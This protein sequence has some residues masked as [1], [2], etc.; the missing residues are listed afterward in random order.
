M[1]GIRENLPSG[2]EIGFFIGAE[3]ES[4]S[5]PAEISTHRLVIGDSIIFRYLPAAVDSNSSSRIGAQ[6]VT[7]IR[8]LGRGIILKREIDKKIT[9]LTTAAAIWFAAPIGMAI[10]FEFYATLLF[11]PS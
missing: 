4:R 9:N 5:K 1:D 8:F 2:Y 3:R 7:D 6:L 11:I 10:G